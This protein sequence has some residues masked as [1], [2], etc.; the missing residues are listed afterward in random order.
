MTLP[1][2]L[3]QIL[4]IGMFGFVRQLLFL[5][6]SSGCG[7]REGFIRSCQEYSVHFMEG[8]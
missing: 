7:W 1:L 2:D 6:D 5:D 8:Y 4:P 3:D